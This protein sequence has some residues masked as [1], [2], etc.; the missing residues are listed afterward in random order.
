LLLSVPSGEALL[1]QV[2]PAFEAYGSGDHEGALALFMSTVSGLDWAT[3]RVLPGERVPGAV[4]HALNDADTFFGIELPA[5]TEWAFGP[6][7]AAAINRPV[8]SVLGTETEPLWVEVADRLR[9]WL[10]QAEDCTIEGVG[11]LLHVQRPEPVARGM[12]GFLARN[13]MTGG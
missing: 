7:Q 3:C 8:L 12:A 10:P 4:A 9:S 2:G 13:S 5:M 11:H 1:Q 6:E